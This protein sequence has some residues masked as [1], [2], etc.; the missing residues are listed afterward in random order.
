MGDSVNVGESTVNVRCRNFSLATL[1]GEDFRH[2]LILTTA[3]FR[4][5]HNTTGQSTNF[6]VVSSRVGHAKCLWKC[7]FLDIL[8]RNSSVT[9][10]FREGA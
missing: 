2:V 8:S 4:H 9:Y 5:L 6:S 1:V 3:V 10:L 7:A